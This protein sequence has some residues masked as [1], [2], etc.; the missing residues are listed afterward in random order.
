MSKWRKLRNWEKQKE[1]CIDQIKF[2]KERSKLL[3]QQ[4]DVCTMCGN[5]CA[6]KDE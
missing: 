6:M 4:E 3:S 1:Y 5:F 2:M